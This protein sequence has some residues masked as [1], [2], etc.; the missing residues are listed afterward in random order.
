ME[1]VGFAAV[2]VLSRGD[3]SH[4]RSSARYV[5]DATQLEGDGMRNECWKAAVSRPKK[6][7]SRGQM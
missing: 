5:V 4:N 1:A 2:L 3:N 6:Q 7:K